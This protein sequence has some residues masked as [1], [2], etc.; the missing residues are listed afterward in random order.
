MRTRVV[1]E[2][3][4][5]GDREVNKAYAR[6][7]MLDSLYRGESPYASHLLFDQPGLLDDDDQNQRELGMDAGFSWGAVA[8]LA[9]VYT[10]RGISDGMRLGIAE[11]E[12]NGIPIVYRMIEAKTT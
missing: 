10:D 6:R 9:A 7:C 3:P 8:T 1:I 4:L 2:S 5:K 12:R 11:H